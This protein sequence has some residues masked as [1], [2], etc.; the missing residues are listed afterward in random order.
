MC[1]RDRD[2]TGGA[3]KSGLQVVQLCLK[4]SDQLILFAVFG[5]TCLQHFLQGTEMCIRDR[6]K[7]LVEVLQ[8]EPLEQL[9]VRAEQR[10]AFHCPCTC[11]LYT[12]RCV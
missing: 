3:K 8:S 5:I 7:D 12:S 2:L 1:I 9:Q 10:L 4:V 11:L 6:A